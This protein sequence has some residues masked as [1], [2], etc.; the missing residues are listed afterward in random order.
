MSSPSGGHG[1][2]VACPVSGRS[3][4]RPGRRAAP[5]PA[6]HGHRR[7]GR[8]GDRQDAGID[9]RDATHWSTRSMATEIGMTQSA[10]SGSGERSGCSRTARSRSSC[11]PT[12]CSWT[13]S[14]TWS[15]S[16]WTRP[17]GRW[18]CAW[19]RS[20]RSRPWTAPPRCCRC[21]PAPAAGH[22]RLQTARHH[23]SVRRSRRRHRPGDRLSALPAPRD[24]VQEVPDQ[25]RPGGPRPTSTCTW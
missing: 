16:T 23:H 25:P 7:A 11:P 3:T 9:A 18:C 21:C 14:R 12:R 2:E 5:G 24:R 4:G 15:G 6:A 19:T 8:G 20:R 10:V 22:P 1:G 13:R 17:S